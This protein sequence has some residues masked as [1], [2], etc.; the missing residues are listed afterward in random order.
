[1]GSRT[2]AWLGDED[3]TLTESFSTCFERL[4]QSAESLPLDNTLPKS[5]KLISRHQSGSLYFVSGLSFSRGRSCNDALSAVV[6]LLS[7]YIERPWFNR[8]WMFQEVLLARECVCCVGAYEL[9]W[10]YV[11]RAFDLTSDITNKPG[12]VGE[13]GPWAPWVRTMYT[14]PPSSSHRN[15]APS[16][17]QLLIETI[18]LECFND[19]DKIYALLGLT[20]GR[21]G[22]RSFQSKSGRTTRIL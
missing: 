5:A 12:N 8:L 3:D 4:R 1:V 21:R 7:W 17:K 13:L 11:Q 15:I 22:E 10:S 9:E 6:A 2:L 16:L 19:R 14:S 18:P 20:H